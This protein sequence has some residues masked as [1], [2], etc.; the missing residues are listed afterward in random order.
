MSE[1]KATREHA[2][3]AEIERLKRR[4]AEP[5]D[6][7]AA[8]RSGEVDAFV[9]T[10]KLG[11]KV[12]VLRDA[13]PPYRLMVEEMKEGAAT[14]DSGQTILYANPRLAELLERSPEW[15]RGSFFREFVAPEALQDWE[16]LLAGANAGRGEVLLRK[17]GGS[18]FPAQVAV[19]AFEEER[20]SAF[21]LVITDLTEQKTQTAASAAEEALRDADRRKN[22]FLAMLGHELRN[23]LAAIANSVQIL[24]QLGPRKPRLEWA[25][26]VIR[27]QVQHIGRIVDDL[28][29]VSRIAMGKIELRREAID[30][31]GLVARVA[32]GYRPLFEER[33]RVLTLSLPSDP[34]PVHGDPTRLAQ[35][36]S[37][38][39]DN[40]VKFSDEGG[41]V[42]VTLSRQGDRVVLTVRDTG[43]GI[44]PETLPRIF[45]LFAQGDRARAGSHGGLG[46]GLAL[47]RNLV[48]LQDGTI[49]ARSG[50]PRLGSEFEVSLPYLHRSE[51]MADAPAG[52]HAGRPR[53]I[54]IVE[55]H[56]D[57]AEGLATLLR[58]D[59]HDVKAVYDGPS[60]LSCATEFQPEAVLLDIGLPG[61]DGYEVARRLRETLGD[62]VLIVALTGYGQDEDRRRSAEA[63]ID[64]HVL[65][66][67]RVDLIAELMNGRLGSE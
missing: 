21:C 1:A 28:L 67:V 56:V 59:G 35:V 42:W 18:T 57:S 43:I 60:A 29:D 40:A 10:E 33:R 48:E 46:I 58:L 51:P 2:L 6:T 24:D 37:N 44:S 62:D 17:D 15:L 20:V 32:D 23:P 7:I 8:I 26:D 55:D 14:L 5:E 31:C 53:H 30:V 9:V 27:R 34:L 41:Q 61:M 49:V 65:K 3:L 12:Y 39:L 54:L 63:K 47:V 36:V 66:P 25:R 19:T 50:G 4:L 13:V 38:L 11:E 45:E 16:S 22:E 52:P 64:H